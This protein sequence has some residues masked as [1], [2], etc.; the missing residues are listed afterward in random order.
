MAITIED[1]PEDTP[2]YADVLTAD[3]RRVAD[4]GLQVAQLRRTVRDL[5]GTVAYFA[6]LVGGAAAIEDYLQ[7]VDNDHMLAG[8]DFAEGLRAAMRG[9]DESMLSAPCG[10]A[11]DAVLEVERG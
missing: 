11:V 1:L 5:S 2:P 8:R 10:A 3:A 7:Q 4:L 6:G 9:L